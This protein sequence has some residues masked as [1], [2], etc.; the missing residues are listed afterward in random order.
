MPCPAEQLA[1]T[2]GIGQL[3]LHLYAAAM[4]GVSAV[5]A[6][7]LY[8]PRRRALARRI[9]ATLTGWLQLGVVISGC[10][11]VYTAVAGFTTIMH[12]AGQSLW[13]HVHGIT[14]ADAE[15]AT[16]SVGHYPNTTGWRTTTTTALPSPSWYAT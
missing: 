6:Y 3:L 5:L 11:H 10:V 4:C 16:S 1:V 12:C 13:F 8:Q 7:V 15:E 9:R 14:P 2:L